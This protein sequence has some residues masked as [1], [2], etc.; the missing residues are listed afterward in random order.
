MKPCRRHPSVCLEGKL[1]KR[2][3]SLS[4]FLVYP[5]PHPSVIFKFL[6]FSI[7]TLSHFKC[8]SLEAI[9]FNRTVTFNLNI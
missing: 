9:I 1:R 7:F 6:L 2:T 3:A 5:V 8:V 4:G